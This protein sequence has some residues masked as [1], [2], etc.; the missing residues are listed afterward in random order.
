METS[1]KEVRCQ[2]RRLWLNTICC[3]RKSS[4]G[5]MTTTWKFKKSYCHYYSDLTTSVPLPGSKQNASRVDPSRGQQSSP[6][7]RKRTGLADPTFRFS[8]DHM[9]HCL[10]CHPLDLPHHVSFLVSC[11]S[12]SCCPSLVPAP[13]HSHSAPLQ[14]SLQ[15]PKGQQPR[16]TSTAL[17]PPSALHTLVEVSDY[18]PT[19][20]K[21]LVLP[22]L[23]VRIGDRHMVVRKG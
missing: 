16:K 23:K 3:R 10:I 5:S 11:T 7:G 13:R 6:R 17:P 4:S 21:V 1:L 9:M 22:G 15:L 14:S 18:P 20:Q 2:S 8:I 12:L 19:A